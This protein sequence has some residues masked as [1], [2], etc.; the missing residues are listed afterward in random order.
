MKS[1]ETPLGA[2]ALKNALVSDPRA[3]LRSLFLTGVAAALPEA[4]LAG[5][6]PEKPKGRTIVIGAGKASAQMAL[7]FEKLWDGPLEGLVVTQYGCAE[8]CKQIEIVEASHPVPDKAG[9]D[10]GQRMLALVAEADRDDLVVALISGGG[11]SLLPAPAPG[12]TLK[13]KQAINRSLLTCGAP[14]SAMNALRK[15]FS[16]IKGGRLAAAAFPARVVSLIISDVPGDDPAL[17]ASGP[18]VADKSG[19]DEARAIAEKY[20]IRLPG[21]AMEILQKDSNPPLAP[22]DPRL[23]LASHSIIASAA[24]SLNAAADAARE[25]GCEVLVLGDALEGEARELGEAHA[26]LVRERKSRALARPLL[27]L[28]GGE[29]S[30]SLG[31]DTPPGGKGGRNS[32]YLLALALG[33]AGVENVAVLAADTDGRDG[34]EDN[35]GAFADGSSVSR[36]AAAG[37]DAQALLDRHDAWSAFDAVND[38]LVTGP[39]G[40]NVNDFRALLIF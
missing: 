16:S 9:F 33:V 12:L 24:M 37:V 40:T 30:V 18:T 25:A 28:S 15:I 39:T 11:S 19:I 27:I 32:E 29:T 17:V 14:I 2:T 4:V 21:A 5:H 10:A 35:A 3:F 6:L 23:A 8:A 7:A 1:F 31:R 13:D 38:L 36:M 34:S 26:R 20:D 22:D